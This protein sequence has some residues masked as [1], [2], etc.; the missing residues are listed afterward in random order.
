MRGRSWGLEGRETPLGNNCVLCGSEAEGGLWSTTFDTYWFRCPDCGVYAMTGDAI[1]YIRND[2]APLS[3]IRLNL[4]AFTYPFRN[5]RGAQ[6]LWKRRGEAVAPAPGLP[7]LARD[8]EDQGEAP[9]AHSGKPNEI[10]RLLATKLAGSEPFAAATLSGGEARALRIA[11]EAELRLWLNV[12]EKGG[13]LRP[14]A[15]TWPNIFLSPD[16]WARVEELYGQ[17]RST[18]A[19]VAMSFTLPERT[20]VQAA[21]I[22]ACKANGWEAKSVDQHEFTGAI[23]DRVLAEINRSRFVVADFTEHKRGVYFE[24]GYGEGRGTPVIYTVQEEQMKEAHFDTSHL[25]HIAW[26][27]PA[28]LR[29]RLEARIG[30][31]INR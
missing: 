6:I 7:Q 31:V 11:G 22:E 19:F 2:T 1:R 18:T 3:P 15:G 16:G 20:E 25:N 26:K 28:D 10:L 5:A 9:I 27:D 14:L 13:L 23:M 24:A 30:A 4:I 21:I 17:A 29:T 8:I 12:L